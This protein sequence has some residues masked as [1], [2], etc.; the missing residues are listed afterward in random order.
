M[1]LKC[2]YSIYYNA[3]IEQ[4]ST[5][6]AAMITETSFI[7]NNGAAPNKILLLKNEAIDRLDSI[8]ADLP[9]YK[10]NLEE[11]IV[12]FTV[13]DML[14]LMNNIYRDTDFKELTHYFVYNEY[15]DEIEDL[16]YKLIHNKLTC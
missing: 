5:K 10:K 4:T 9:K 8:V 13:D 16:I 14:W 1:K 7:M 2:F 3:S 12:N 15:F 11:L 6:M